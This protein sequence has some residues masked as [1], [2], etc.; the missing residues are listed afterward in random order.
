MRYFANDHTPLLW[1]V[2]QDGF[3]DQDKFAEASCPIHATLS[4]IFSG[5]VLPR[6]HLVF[7]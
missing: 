6:T 5:I 4:G 1:G 2:W 3:H 7:S